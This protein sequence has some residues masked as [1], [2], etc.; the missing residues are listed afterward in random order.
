ML[1]WDKVGLQALEKAIQIKP[2]Y[3]QAHYALGLSYLKLG[4]KNSALKEFRIL[5]T[6]DQNLADEL[7]RMINN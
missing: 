3:A 6:L 5:K 7:I 1:G 4:D 2:K